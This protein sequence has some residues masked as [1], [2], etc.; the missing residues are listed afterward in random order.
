MARG[1]A[2]RRTKAKGTGPA[3]MK[4]KHYKLDKTGKVV[5][6]P[7]TGKPIVFGFSGLLGYRYHPTKG[8][9]KE[10]GFRP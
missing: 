3:K 1:N 8:Y 5:T 6:S 4:A 9:K 10:A 7:T 2:V